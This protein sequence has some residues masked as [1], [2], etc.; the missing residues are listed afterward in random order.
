MTRRA[1]GRS[2]GK[3]YEQTRPINALLWRERSD[4]SCQHHLEGSGGRRVNVRREE[5]D[6]WEI[7]L[8]RCMD[9]K[10]RI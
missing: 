10:E 2:Y 9:S 6:L 1:S 4:A 7:A 5:S 8:L 3:R